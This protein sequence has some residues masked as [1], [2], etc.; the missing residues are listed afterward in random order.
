MKRFLDVAFALLG[1]AFTSPI[2]LIISCW[3]RLDSPGPIFFKQDRVGRNGDPF[4][5]H[6][7]RSMRVDQG[8]ALVTVGD[9][10]RITR[11]GR[12][13]RRTKL[14]ELP[15]LFDVLRGRM[16]LVGPR[17]EVREYVD[18]W[19][20]RSRSLILSVR[21]GITDP[22]SIRFRNESELLA[23]AQDPEAEY[24]NVVLPMK[25]R[26]YEEYVENQTLSG[27]LKIIM[28]TL[29]SVLNG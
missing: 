18:L 26:L 6:K 7:F 5:I 10:P 2:F 29:A 12:F 14:D 4:T 17:P 23:L 28:K 13:I 20:V 21:P 11:S 27:D 25:V 3:V 24:R 8:G 22:A 16:S 19:P 15:Q 9:D 1:L